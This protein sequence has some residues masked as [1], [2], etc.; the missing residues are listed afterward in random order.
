LFYGGKKNMNLS[1]IIGKKIEQTQ[2]FLEDGTRVP[3]TRVFVGDNSISQI[4][5]SEKDGYMAVQVAFGKRNKISKP[6]TGHL[7]KAGLK[8]TP[9]F[10]REI[11]VDDVVGF[12]SGTVV[13]PEEVLSAGDKI[14]V[15]GV[16]KGKGFAG[17]VKRWGFHG[18]PKTH[19]QSDRHRAPGSIGQGTTPGRVYKG[20]KMA[21][22]MGSD[23]VT[24]KNLEI[25]DVKDGEILIKG[26]I[27]GPKN[28]LVM[29]TKIGENKKFKPLFSIA[30]EEI[31]E[32]SDA[33]AI[34]GKEKVDKVVDAEAEIEK[35][36][37]AN[38]TTEVS[39]E[40]AAEEVKAEEV[41]DEKPSEETDEVAE[42]TGDVKSEDSK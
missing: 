34:E 18:G 13:T 41:S 28:G 29:I 5:T 4:K 20:K 31:V 25:A 27:P 32:P 23:R 7:K 14:D 21:G 1:A 19:G 35:K 8:N 12:E 36:V 33:K 11:R 10:L 38:E 37:E 24:I 16:S 2:A 40:S 15:V 17:A 22:R 6:L 30:S 26:L 3:L 42:K 39:E 9:R